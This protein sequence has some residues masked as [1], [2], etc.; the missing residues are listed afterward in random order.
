MTCVITARDFNPI[1]TDAHRDDWTTPAMAAVI[2]ALAGRKVAITTDAH[3]GSTTIGA[4]LAATVGGQVLVKTDALPRGTFFALRNIG[5][6]LPLEDQ[7]TDT[8][9]SSALTIFRTRQ[10]AA[11]EAA[12]AFLMKLD[13]RNWGELDVIPAPSENGFTV[14][15]LPEQDAPA[16]RYAGSRILLRMEEW[17]DGWTA[18]VITDWTNR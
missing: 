4:T 8:T 7:I 13:G 15:Y 3:T 14:R 18:R 6:V 11:R 2:T 16:G 17:Q 5:M 1:T 9:K 12:A 10:T